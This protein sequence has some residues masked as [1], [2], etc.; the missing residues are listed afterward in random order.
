MSK[1]HSFSIYL[2]K[3]K[4]NVSNALKEEHALGDPIDATNLPEGATLFVLDPAPNPPW[5][6][7]F[8]GVS[9]IVKQVLKGA[10]LFLPVEERC[11]ALTFGHTHHN[12]KN[13]CYEYDFGLRVTLNSLDPDKLKST[14]IIEPGIARRQRI[15]S[16][17]DSDLTFF[18]FDRDSSIIKTLTGKVKD[19]YA[20]F[21]KH[22]TGA[23]SLRISSK[24]DPNEVKQLCENILEIYNKNDYRE[25]FPDI[26]NVIPVKDPS[27]VKHLDN[28]LLEA[29][30][31]MSIDLVLTIP[32]VVDYRGGFNITFSGAGEGLIYEDVYIQYYREYLEENGISGVSIEMLSSHCVII[33][34]EEGNK[35]DSF[36]I[37][38]CFLFESILDDFNYHF[39][40][41]N[42]YRIEKSYIEKL[43]NF[44]DPHFEYSDLIDF[45]HISE[46]EYNADVSEQDKKY[47]CLDGKNI[48]SSGQHQVEPCDL[49]TVKDGMAVY[50][51]VKRS[52]RSSLLSHLFN[53]GINSVELIKLESEAKIR[54]RQLVKE[55]LSGNDEKKYLEPIGG[56]HEKVVYEIITHKDKEKKS[57][58][59][60]IFSRISLRRSIKTFQLMSVDVAVCFILNKREKKKGKKKA[61]KR[62]KGTA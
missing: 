58:N 57:N 20:L 47:I 59:L 14:D 22:A 23:S 21:F 61:R 41:G 50:R 18:D 53:Q 26:Q 24:V 60:P 56:G 51:H 19:E 34:D 44:L 52:T 43:K 32:Q 35:K 17:T 5:W 30:E 46:P 40:E 28:K 29:F 45:D 62:K 48:S 12:L 33:C 6:I 49:Y 8:W 31:S 25:S 1:S 2:L 27:T 11:F 55:N 38:K 54:M 16:P 13:D 4:F 39:C 10:I 42:W 36:S 7:K 9:K 15:Q 3:E 37:Y